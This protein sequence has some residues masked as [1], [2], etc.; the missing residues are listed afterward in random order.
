MVCIQLPEDVNMLE[1]SLSRTSY[2]LG[3]I[4]I[5]ISLFLNTS[6]NASSPHGAKS[7]E[8]AETLDFL[9][10]GMQKLN[11]KD[12]SAPSSSASPG[13]AASEI[14]EEDRQITHVTQVF[15]LPDEIWKEHI[16]NLWL[17]PEEVLLVS[18]GFNA[19][20]RKISCWKIVVSDYLKPLPHPACC[21]FRDLF[22]SKLYSFKFI[23]LF[24]DPSFFI[25]TEHIDKLFDGKLSI[26]LLKLENN[27]PVD[28]EHKPVE[29]IIIVNKLCEILKT[30]M[31]LK[32]LNLVFLGLENDSA[33]SLKESLQFNTSLQELTLT[34]NRIDKKTCQQLKE[35]LGKR[36]PSLFVDENKEY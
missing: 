3:I 12:E 4:F 8:S 7:P 30:N 27:H 18:K 19:L 13:I 2:Y 28:Q 15:G 31:T 29:S 9:Q 20:A 33:I 17:M 16:L 36:I 10:Q 35:E 21:Y 26:S 25:Q 23:N 24:I 14:K 34:W 11:L 32:S 1:N 6:S 22:Q 5:S